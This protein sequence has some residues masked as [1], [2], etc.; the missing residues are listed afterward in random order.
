MAKID[1]SNT[2]EDTIYILDAYGLIYRSYF[3][4][5]SRPLSNSRGENISAV[6]GFFRNLYA[7]I[8]H[9]APK[10]VVAAFDSITP[11]FRHKMYPEYKATRNKTPEDLHAQVPIIKEILKNLGVPIL[12]YEGFEADDIIASVAKLAEKNSRQCRILSGDKDLMQLVS[13]T[14]LMLKP[15]SGNIWK[16]VDAEGVK[17]EWGVYPE[18]M[19]DLLSLT[20]DSA[21]NIPGVAGVGP[22]TA[23]KYIE[24]YG[25]LD[26]IYNHADEVK[27]VAGEKLRSGKDNAYFS[28]K[29][30]QL[31]EDVPGI[32]NLNDIIPEVNFD[33]KTA[34]ENLKFYEVNSVAKSYAELALKKN[35]SLKQDA[36]T[37]KNKSEDSQKQVPLVQN[38]GQYKSVTN[39]E[40]LVNI[41]DNI[42]LTKSIV[43]FDCETTGLNTLTS[44]IVGFSLSTKKG[45]GV[46]VPLVLGDALF[47]EKVIE[48]KSAIEQIKR[49]F[50]N[51]NTTVIMHN[52]KF[53]YEILRSNG[54]TFE[55]EYSLPFCKIA[56]TMIAAWLLDP[57]RNTSTS[58]ALEYL[59]ETKL[60]IQ[61]IE[62]TSI[63]PKGAFFS[64]VPLDVATEYAAE[65]ADFT[66]QLWNVLEKELEKNDLL[67][68]FFNTEM[69]V[70]PILAEMELRGIHID[71]K[72]LNEYSKELKEE[73]N[74][75]QKEIFSL[76]GH[77]FNIASPK[78][79]Q[80]VLFE[81]LK[82][83][84]GKKTK[85]GF[86]TDTSV[87]EEISLYHPV[88]EKIIYHR[89]KT[90]LYSTY[91]DALPK[92]C[93][94]N[95]RVH[96]NY[97]QIGTATG[98][99]SSRDPNLQNIP[100]KTED[101]KR[102]RSAFTSPK[103]Y[104]LIS[105]DYSQI[106]LVVLAHLSCDKNMQDAFINGK[107]IHK[108][109]ASRLFNILPE[110]VSSSERR[111]AK[112]INFGI[113]YGMSAFRLAKD[114]NISRTQASS[115]I[116]NYFLQ[117]SAIKK[118]IDK[119]ILDAQET[120]FAKT[121]FGR[122][123]K[124]ASIHSSN[125][126]EKAAADRIAVNTPVQGSAADIVKKAMINIHSRFLEEQNGT[127]LLLQVHDELIFECPISKV[128]ESVKIIREEMEGAVKLSVPLRVSIESGTN[129]GGFH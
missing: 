91:V 110:N 14:T 116:E 76:V 99:L 18:K 37:E 109:T 44:N 112:T 26:E 4:L 48:K 65:D 118:F 129:W 113:I 125:K 73:I 55:N 23:C 29:L 59:A 78:Q 95:G 89:E 24:Q 115:F 126:V 106:E 61:G 84:H 124:I 40:E 11:T 25:D 53:D 47:A 22:K 88:I 64:D 90:K 66:L 38:K 120:G 71:T 2:H 34:S 127:H 105:A 97:L 20:G 104:A 98:R 9:Y 87:L 31:R 28:K 60:H 15:D 10:F 111:I 94:K 79:L 12:Q 62:Y 117:Y 50:T 77:E 119:C 45:S 21:D 8:T 81:E 114:L 13:K 102:I 101:G 58:Y 57:E 80:E 49:L 7:L 52:G 83:P 33:F 69:K 16:L 41:I 6:F 128:E 1:S 36:S 68:L 103:G 35:H 100:V 75:S 96:T 92:L 123:R 39:L 85:T 72:A 17:A 19:L 74:K 93:D 70:L 121:I 54:L 63:V 32:E 30:I 56:D 27:G 46:Y 5:I 82:L 42:I 108:E 86:S 3:A 43:A 51:H 107:D 67:D 122:K